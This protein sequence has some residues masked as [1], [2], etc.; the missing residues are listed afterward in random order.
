MTSLS[1][2]LSELE[3]LDI[4]RLH[5]LVYGQLLPQLITRDGREHA[6]G[7]LLR[8]KVLGGLG[9][10]ATS[11]FLQDL[12]A[13]TPASRDREHLRLDIVIDPLMATLPDASPLPATQTALDSLLKTDK[14]TAFCL[15][16]NTAHWRLDHLVYDREN[17]VFV[18]M[19]EATVQA[20][21]M[22]L[23]EGDKVG[24]LATSRMVE[25]GL[26]QDAF[27]KAGIPSIP[28][29]PEFQRIVDAVIYGGGISG[30]SHAGVKGGETGPSA[31]TA[32]QPVVDRLIHHAGVCAVCLACTE[33]PLVFGPQRDGSFR[34]EA[35]GAA[36]VNSTRALAHAFLKQALRLQVRVLMARLSN[37]SP[38]GM[39]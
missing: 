4:A 22:H 12:L 17:V 27:A 28:P 35:R 21:A 37:P 9:P 36:F 30:Q 25:S 15:V 8:F 39:H 2:T 1:S 20:V 7:L 29:E 24:L 10:A 13:A 38:A 33:L 26:Y 34:G 16:C 19:V 23:M 14:P 3:N 5:A 32:L 31:T 6:E 11:D 18:S